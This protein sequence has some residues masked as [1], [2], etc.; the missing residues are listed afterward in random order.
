METTQQDKGI[1]RQLITGPGQ[2]FKYH[3]VF[4]SLFVISCLAF[5]G[6]AVYRFTYG[7]GVTGLND[8]TAWGIWTAFKLALVVVSGCAFVLTGMVYVFKMEN[9]RPLCRSAA[10]I[11]LLGYST[12]AITLVFELGWPWRIVHPIWMHNYH[13]I[14]FEIAWC[15]MLYLTVLSLEFVP[16]I[17]ERFNKMGLVKWYKKLIPSFVI[18]GIILSVLHQS[19]LGSLFVVSPY[20]LNHLWYSPWVGPFF[21]ISAVFCGLALV[22]L[23][24]FFMARFN[25]RQARVNLLSKLACYSIP[26]LGLYLGFKVMDVLERT[27]AREAFGRMDFLTF[28]YIVEIGGGV[29]LPMILFGIKKVRES[30][31]GLIFTSLLVVL[32]GGAL[33]RLNVSVIA[34]DHSPLG[35][36]P[37]LVEYL[38]IPATLMVVA[39]IYIILTRLFPI[40]PEGTPK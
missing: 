32:L 31:R 23:V 35:Y 18:A 33:N 15:V 13:S 36:S 34:M 38:Y 20:K 3:P 19:S 5:L 16:N 24:E 21:I 6:I 2:A 12:F 40:D 30:A 7:L 22:I 17:L 10:L 28:L 29:L 27:P 11:G 26:F 1:I 25:K 9:F 37:T 4:T 39:G 8:N 14:L